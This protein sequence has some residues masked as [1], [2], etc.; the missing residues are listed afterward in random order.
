[1]SYGMTAALQTAVFGALS[2]DALVGSLSGG[3]IYDALPSGPVP[4]FYVSLGPERVLDRSD[5]TGRA[6]L[7][8]FPVTVISDAAGFASAK[9]L[10]AAISD[11]L[12]DADLTLS[13]GRLV[14]LRF[15]RARAR[16]VDTGR[17]I[18]IWFRARVDDGA[19]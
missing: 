18:E 10:A 11:V 3:A 15:L 2:A 8:D 12:V 16:R 1:M 4:D 9:A 13:R 14:S 19:T 7:H 17:E 6:A 5:K